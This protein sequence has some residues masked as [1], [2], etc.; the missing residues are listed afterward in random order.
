MISKN[1]GNFNGTGRAVCCSTYVSLVLYRSGT[2][3]ADFMNK[4]NYN[5]PEGLD[6]MLTDAGWELVS[7]EEAQPG[8]IC[9]F[10]ETEEF[11]HSFIYA[12]G[13]EIYD[14]RSGAYGESY[15]EEPAY[16]TR[17]CWETWCR[18]ADVRVYR[19]P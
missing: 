9:N 16:G 14:Q 5:T 6:E 17:E 7:E 4:Y 11:R 8:D 19:M 3:T 13:N 10:T 15:D 12:G 1:L 18:D 2:F